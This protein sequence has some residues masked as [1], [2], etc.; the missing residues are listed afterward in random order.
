[1]HVSD[2]AFSNTPSQSTTAVLGGIPNEKLQY[3]AGDVC[4]Q[5]LV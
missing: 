4:L 5:A 3:R 1:M 2:I